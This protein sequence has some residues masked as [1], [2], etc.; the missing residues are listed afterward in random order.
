MAPCFRENKMREV[1]TRV[2]VVDSEH[3][4][5]CNTA[6]LVWGSFVFRPR[7]AFRHFPSLVRARGEPGNKAKCGVRSGSPQINFFFTFRQHVV[8]QATNSHTS[9]S[10]NMAMCSL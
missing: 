2:V 5:V 7:P 9:L 3:T 6:M 1:P 10:V 8:T 4:H